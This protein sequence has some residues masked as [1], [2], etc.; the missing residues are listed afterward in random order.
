[1]HGTATQ[2]YPLAM[3]F[4]INGCHPYMCDTSARHSNCFNQFR[5]NNRKNKRFNPAETLNFPL[6]RGE[7]LDGEKKFQE[8]S[9]VWWFDAYHT[10]R[11]LP[12]GL[13]SRL[14]CIVRVVP[15]R[16]KQLRWYSSHVAWH[17][18]TPFLTYFFC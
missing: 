11:I 16:S 13:N 5:R 8:D 9:I 3:L 18:N 14:W 12:F 6:C 2:C 1:M 4:L 7:V 17:R 10:S 15:R